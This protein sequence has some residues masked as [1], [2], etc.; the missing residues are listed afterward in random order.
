KLTMIIDSGIRAGLDVIRAKAL[1]AR[2]AFSGR[3]FLYAMAAVGS[4]GG[5]QVIEIY[6]DEIKRSL[7]QLGC[8]EFESMDASWLEP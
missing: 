3:S 7:Q 6:R 4:D 5:R 2:A 1:G 8:K